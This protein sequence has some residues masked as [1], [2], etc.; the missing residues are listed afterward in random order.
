MNTS[1]RKKLEPIKKFQTE[2]QVIKILEN[3]DNRSNQ[4]E[5]RVLYL[6]NRAV[7]SDLLMRDM[8]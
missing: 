4:Y 7:V 8:L 5:D 6:E 2:I 1:H 3:I